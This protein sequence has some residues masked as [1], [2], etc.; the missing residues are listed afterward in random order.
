MKNKDEN[1]LQKNK[2]NNRF[3]K[4]SFFFDKILDFYKMDL[5]SFY[6]TFFLV[7]FASYS[8]EYFINEFIFICKKNSFDYFSNKKLSLEQQIFVQHLFIDIN[9]MYITMWRKKEL[10][11]RY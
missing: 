6:N 1:R 2:I 7:C 5:N 8:Q 9:S 11:Y 3:I 10:V 4:Y